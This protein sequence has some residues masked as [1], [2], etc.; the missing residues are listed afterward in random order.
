MISA[1]SEFVTD[2]ETATVAL[3]LGDRFNRQRVTARSRARLRPTLS[4]S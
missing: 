3:R 2:S 4:G 1:T